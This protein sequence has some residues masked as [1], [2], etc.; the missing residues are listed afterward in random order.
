MAFEAIADV[1]PAGHFFATEHTMQRYKTAF[2]EPLVADW[3]NY[4]QWSENGALRADE[5]ATHIWKERL[6]AFRPPAGAAE[7]VSRIEPIIARRT[8]EGG[9]P[10]ID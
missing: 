2:W 3:S 5:R 9:A 1:T 10:V 4:G 8:A 6:A 7:R